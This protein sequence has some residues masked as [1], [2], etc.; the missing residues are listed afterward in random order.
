MYVCIS[1]QCV[2][3]DKVYI[4]ACLVQ[5]VQ[6][7]KVCITACLVQCVQGDKVYITA[8]LVQCVQGDICR[9]KDGKKYW[10]K[11]ITCVHI[12]RCDS[13][14]IPDKIKRNKSIFQ[15]RHLICLTKLKLKLYHILNTIKT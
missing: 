5:C 6:G 12:Q 14:K 2:Q 4:S 13:V 8:C 1:L 11:L 9:I 10:H 3:G 7:D 15:I